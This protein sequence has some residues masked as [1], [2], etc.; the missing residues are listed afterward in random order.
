MSS[1]ENF[2]AASD[3]T[4]RAMDARN[5]AIEAEVRR[6]RDI[7][8]ASGWYPVRRFAIRTGRVLCGIL[9]VA[10]S[11]VVFDNKRDIADLPF[12]QLSIGAI[13]SNLGHWFAGL[14]A[15][16]WAWGAAFGAKPTP[17]VVEESVRAQA[18]QNVD[19]R[20]PPK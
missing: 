12:S 13:A 17:A 2:Y 7:H 1:F 6:L 16:L 14:A 15:L 18:V 4:V 9:L 8:F 20:N 10:V 11:V 3:R 19:L 5:A